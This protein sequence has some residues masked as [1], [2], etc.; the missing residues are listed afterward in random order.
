MRI[1]TQ[2]EEEIMAAYTVVFDQL[3]HL[4]PGDAE[5]TRQLAERLLPHLPLASRVADFG[6]GIGAP[7]MVLAQSLPS[8]RILAVNAHQSFIARLE[9]AASGVGERI[10][11]GLSHHR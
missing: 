10:S 3:V 1:M 8:A 4:G 5:T 2:A 9:T 6:C 7:T 11:W